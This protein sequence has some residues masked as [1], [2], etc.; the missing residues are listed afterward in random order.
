M[1]TW[2]VG[3]LSLFIVAAGTGR[4][5]AA[6]TQP[7]RD[8]EGS[9]LA[10]IVECSSCRSGSGGSKCHGGV[11]AGW[12]DGKACGTCLI[13]ANYG[14][15]IEY[16][17]DLQMYGRLVDAHGE[18]VKERFVKLFIANGWNVRTRTGQDGTFRLVL[19]ATGERKSTAALPIDLGTRVDSPKENAGHH[20]MFLLPD[21]Y[22]A[23]PQPAARSSK[24]GDNAK[25]KK[26]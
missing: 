8:P 17:Y 5:L 23:C 24:A 18:P 1:Q 16:P 26:P 15:S 6:S 2:L 20:A 3:V 21:H 14:A 9:T 13:E 4:A 12:L 22:A 10:V 11:E 19:G 7:V 25:S